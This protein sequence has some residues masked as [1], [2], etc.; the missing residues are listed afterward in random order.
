VQATHIPSTT[1]HPSSVLIPLSHLSKLDNVHHIFHVCVEQKL[2]LC[3]GIK[4][5]VEFG[6]CVLSKFFPCIDNQLHSVYFDDPDYHIAIKCLN[7]CSANE[8][9][10]KFHLGNCLIK[11]YK[12][13]SIR[14]N[15]LSL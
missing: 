13:H 6:V 7:S 4:Q 15:S 12:G 2:R 8:E 11:C 3:E 14:P 9:T 1:S 5:E 10:H